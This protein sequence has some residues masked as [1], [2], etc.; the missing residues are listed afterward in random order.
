MYLE[1]CTFGKTFR[2]CKPKGPKII[3]TKGMYLSFKK[4]LIVIFCKKNGAIARPIVIKKKYIGF[5]LMYILYPKKL[6]IID[7]FPDKIL[8]IKPAPCKGAP[9]MIPVTSLK[10]RKS[11]NVHKKTNQSIY[12]FLIKDKINPNTDK[13]KLQVEEKIKL[14][15]RAIKYR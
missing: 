3:I 6:R 9:I 14:M 13:K 12:F 8:R 1:K 10:T 5:V 2:K 15:E 4:V 11:G 7:S